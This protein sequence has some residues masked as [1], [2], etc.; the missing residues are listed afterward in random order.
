MRIEIIP[1]TAKK[2]E[3]AM[4]LNDIV[5]MASPGSQSE[6]DGPPTSKEV[7]SI[8]ELGCSPSTWRPIDSGSSRRNRYPIID[9]TAKTTMPN[10]II[11]GLHP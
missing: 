5:P 4:S 9:V 7:S 2:Y 6:A 8:S 10:P 1:P 11:V 3:T